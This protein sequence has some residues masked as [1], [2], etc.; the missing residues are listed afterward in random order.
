MFRHLVRYTLD[1][2]DEYKTRT[3]DYIDMRARFEIPGMGDMVRNCTIRRW[4]KS[5]GDTVARGE[6]IVEVAVDMIDAELPA[7]FTGAITDIFAHPG[8][9]VH[10]GKPIAYIETDDQDASDF[11]VDYTTQPPSY[12]KASFWNRT[13]TREEQ[14][15]GLAFLLALGALL[16]Y[17]I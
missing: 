11:I 5:V 6:M 17:V 14:I 3:D 8:D 2:P 13:F 1:T 12:P 15:K 9:L 7:P 16:A 4:K 10:I